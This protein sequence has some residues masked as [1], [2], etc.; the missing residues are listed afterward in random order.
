MFDERSLEGETPLHVAVSWLTGLKLLFKL[1]RGS[2]QSLINVLDA[3]NSTPLQY[4]LWLESPEAVKTLFQNGADTELEMPMPELPRFA[5][6]VPHM[7]IRT[8]G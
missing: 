6:N 5:R 2:A 1:S 7:A 3:R 4:A 8:I